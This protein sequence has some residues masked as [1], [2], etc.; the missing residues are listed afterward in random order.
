[1]TFSRRLFSFACLSV[2]L[3]PFGAA[4]AYAA[5]H[6]VSIKGMKFTPKTLEIAAGDRVTFTNHDSA[7]HSATGIEGGFDTGLL[8]AE[9][10]VTVH[11]DAAGTY[12]YLCSLHP[13]MKGTILV[14]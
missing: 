11:F 4:P 9:Q 7:K 5:T 13:M 6:Q 1:M 8:G 12:D 3:M 2:P 14:S 10:S